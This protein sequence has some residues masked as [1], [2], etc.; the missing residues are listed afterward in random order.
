MKTLVI[1]MKSTAPNHKIAKVIIALSVPII[2]S[3]TYFI[4]LSLPKLNNPAPTL[5]SISLTLTPTSTPQTYNVT[6]TSPIDY[7]LNAFQLNL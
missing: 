3:L 6:V 1:K 4:V 5:T 2:L 7:Q